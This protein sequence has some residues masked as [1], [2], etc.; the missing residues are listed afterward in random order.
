MVYV[1]KNKLQFYYLKNKNINNK[2]LVN[3][4]TIKFKG[5]FSG[6]FFSIFSLLLS[7]T[8]DFK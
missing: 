2:K 1:L 8:I 3:D 4:P 7:A 5:P 6:I